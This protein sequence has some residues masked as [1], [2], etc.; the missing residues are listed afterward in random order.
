MSVTEQEHLKA[1]QIIQQ[2]ILN[3]KYNNPEV[4]L[5]YFNYKAYR[6]IIVSADPS[7]I[8][9]AID[10]VFQ[11]K[12]SLRTIIRLDSSNYKFK[13]ELEKHH[14][15][16][17]EKI[18]EHS[19]KLGKKQNEHIL[20]LRMA[21]FKNP[22]YEL[23]KLNI[24]DFSV[25]K[26]Y[27]T[28]AEAKYINPID[29]KGPK[30]YLYKILDTVVKSGRRAVRVYF[31][32][33]NSKSS[34]GLQGVLTLDLQSYAVANFVTTFNGGIKIKASQKFVYFKGDNGWF[35]VETLVEIRN[36]NN[37]KGVQFF[38]RLLDFDTENK[39]NKK[40]EYTANQNPSDVVF[41]RSK[42]VL[43]DIQIN[44]P[45][46][47][48]KSSSVISIASDAS[49]KEPSFWKLYRK[50]PVTRRDLKTYLLI[51]SISKAG[52]IE[53]KIDVARN[54][55]KG[56]YPLHFLNLDLGKIINLNNYEGLR[57]GLGGVT[58]E[59]FSEKFRIESYVAYG[60]KDAAIKYKAG[61]AVRLNN[62]ANTWMGLN[63]TN[64]IHES[65]GIDF[66]IKGTSFSPINPRNLNL[67]H[68]YKYKTWEAYLAHDIQPN[69]TAKANLT[70]GSYKSTFY[71]KYISNKKL[72]S[73]YH[74]TLATVAF[75]YSPNSEYLSSPIGKIRV[76]NGFPQYTL[77]LR[78]SLSHVWKSDFGFAQVNFKV[79]H[80]LK[81]LKKGVTHLLMVGGITFGETPLSHLYNATPNYTYKNPYRKRITFG[82]KNSF[83]TMGYNEFISD[84]YVMFQFKHFFEPFQLSK[85]FKP[86]LSFITRFGIGAM[87]TPMNQVGVQFKTME[88]GYL[89]SGVEINRLFKG[90]GF[91][92]FYRYGSYQL[93]DWS[94]N[95]AV[96]LTYRL[97]L[98]F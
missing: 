18:S 33:R 22:I 27:Y 2:A 25:Y 45:L 98:G 82:G 68:F 72:L 85:F 34:I 6:K 24:Q 61:G 28:I 91:S 16:I 79:A 40:Y 30:M 58:N 81:P 37:A 4:S 12:K 9:R 17:T 73:D 62:F 32:P 50:E 63:F 19:F 44:K 64:D 96:K 51:D 39:K 5:G 88:K 71:Y 36:G 75:N 35:P 38:N 65:A 90:F 69:F 52:N 15:Y 31:T 3:K 41:L 89:E 11:R 70:A 10:T 56:F 60:T 97:S 1:L 48:K 95:L 59:K 78:K 83:E 74:L 67:S 57:V 66:I 87:R 94:D 54:L 23:L 53:R 29:V 47:I 49:N 84:R 43:F 7:V 86:H 42:T 80:Q 14:L 77:Q 20:A 55:L 92:A 21:G 8:S 93:E 76:K 26:K 46:E 13:K